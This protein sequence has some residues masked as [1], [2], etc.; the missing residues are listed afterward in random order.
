[1]DT[2][3]NP[4]IQL[5]QQ[6]L[7]TSFDS[8]WS[9]ALPSFKLEY[10]NKRS[11]E[12]LLGYPVETFYHDSE[13]WF[14][15]IYQEDKEIAL[16]ANSDCL[17]HGNSEAR[18]RM[19]RADG[20]P[21]W[22][23]C[24]QRLI[25]DEVGTPFRLIGSTMDINDA[26]IREQKLKENEEMFHSLVTFVPIGIYITDLLGRSLYVNPSWEYISGMSNAE[27]LGDNWKNVIH[28]EDIEQTFSDW[29]NTVLQNRTFQS[30]FRFYN[31][32][33][34]VRYVSSRAAPFSNA[35]GVHVGYVGTIED[36]TDRLAAEK[37]LVTQR[38]KLV[39]SSK[40]S[41]LGEMA[42]GIAHEINNPLMIIVG[43]CVRLKRLAYA[44]SS[45]NPQYTKDV[46]KIEAT[47]FRIS[48]IIKGLRNFSRNSDKDPMETLAMSR[49]IEDT[50]ELSKQRFE[51][52]NIELSIDFNRCE[53]VEIE[54]RPSQ[55]TQVLLNLISNSFDVV[56]KLEQRWVRIALDQEDAEVLIRITDS[57]KGIT[58]EVVKKMMEPFFSTKEVG[59]GTGLG[60]SISKGIVEE[61]GGKLSYDPS[62]MNTRFVIRFKKNLK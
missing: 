9:I 1:M 5:L 21:I 7:E 32:K 54:A 49:I 42:S 22:V 40:M 19:V 27:A 58:P 35:D 6:V 28:H 24:R 4:D 62:S 47:T 26:T 52:N 55:I 3:S 15:T 30:E 45:L 41:S 18:F 37:A 56:E 39:A 12:K 33:R 13:F 43:L 11:T 29:K 17:L 23:L 25:K 34:G 16:Q 2:L 36:I 38:E 61:H 59:K 10:A 14:S 48:K 51:D 31:K 50:L 8:S 44:E 57:G 46:E 60:L 53:D 20:V